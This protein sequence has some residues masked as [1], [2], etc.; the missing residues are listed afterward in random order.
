MILPYISTNA[1]LVLSAEPPPAAALAPAVFALVPTTPTSVS[2]PANVN[3]TGSLPSLVTVMTSPS[4][5]TFVPS[6]LWIFL[7]GPYVEALIGNKALNAALSAITAAVVGVVLNLAGWFAMQ[8]LFHRVDVFSVAGLSV[9][10]P[11]P[12]TIDWRAFAIFAAATVALFRFRIGMVTVLAASC[13]AELA[14]H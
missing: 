12:A 6:F 3:A 4:M 11:D 1:G 14:L 5:A 10:F 2:L 9:R 7:G 13:L 8:S